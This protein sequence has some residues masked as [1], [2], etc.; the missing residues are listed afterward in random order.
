MAFAGCAVA[1]GAGLPAGV[2][3]AAAGAA[4]GLAGAGAT[5][6]LDGAGR[7]A[8]AGPGGGTDARA[9]SLPVELVLRID[10]IARAEGRCVPE[11]V[12]ACSAEAAAGNGA[13]FDGGG[14]PAG[15]P[16][17]GIDGLGQSARS[18]PHDEH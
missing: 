16:C 18:F 14:A 13:R 17:G 8:A 6:G 2:G 5:F 10:I 1:D 7:G 11:R 3:V 15:L 9:P 12:F 4:A